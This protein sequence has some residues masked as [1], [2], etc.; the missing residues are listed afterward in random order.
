M[1]LWFGGFALLLLTFGAPIAGSGIDSLVDEQ[2]REAHRVRIH[3]ETAKLTQQLREA[4][5]PEAESTWWKKLVRIIVSGEQRL[6]HLGTGAILALAG[7]GSILLGLGCLAA[8]VLWN[9]QAQL[10]W[11][12]DMQADLRRIT[13]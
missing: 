10:A 6:S 2:K 1:S 11:R 3:E 4:G 5:A 7:V 8:E 9:R 12:L 13:P